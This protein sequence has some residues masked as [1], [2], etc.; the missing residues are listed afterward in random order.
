MNHENVEI[1]DADFSNVV[2][3]EEQY[4][5]VIEASTLFNYDE[6]VERM[7]RW[8]SGS[9]CCKR[10]KCNKK[11]TPQIIDRQARLLRALHSGATPSARRNS[12]QLDVMHTYSLTWSESN[13]HS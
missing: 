4:S 12:F 10:D 8:R 7:N 3:N 1:D 2:N 6:C 13:S 5:G 11:M 9:W